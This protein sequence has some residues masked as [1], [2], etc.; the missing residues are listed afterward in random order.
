MRTARWRYTEWDGGK[1][2]VELYDHDADPGEC[3]NLAGEP[4]SAE[5]VQELKRLLETRTPEDS[6]R[7]R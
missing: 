1:E 7:K 4:S 5:R 6:A 2:G 3:H